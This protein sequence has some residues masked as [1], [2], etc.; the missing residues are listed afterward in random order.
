MKGYT[1]LLLTL[2]FSFS[3]MPQKIAAI[4]DKQ[5]I[6]IGQ[7]FH[8]KLQASFSNGE[9]VDFFV[10]DTIP[11]FEIL[12]RSAVDTSKVEGG[13]TLIQNFT[14][15]SW[16]SGKL[17]IAPFISGKNKT[18][19]LSI[20]VMYAPSPFDTTQPYHD[21]HDVFDVKQPAPTTWYW[22]VIGILFFIL[23]F[24]LFFPKGKSKSK[25]EFI[26][27]EGAYKKA[28]KKLNALQKRNESDSKIFYTELIQTFREYLHKRKN[29]Y[30]F[31]KTTDDLSIQI[32][33][34]NMDKEKYQQLVQTLQL[35]DMVKYAKY[36]PTFQENQTAFNSVKNSIIAIE[37]VPTLN[38]KL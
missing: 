4:A 16:D 25:G 9:A 13:V 30:S 24:I 7:P 2:L 10:V 6:L 28:I 34:L 19:P 21:V 27:D 26:A 23:L 32:E 31:S 14:M 22:Y 36:Q 3:A 17:Q 11:H 18:N 35:S 1:I 29:M 15:T 12:K 5:K 38:P 20:D 37:Q 8:L 33:K